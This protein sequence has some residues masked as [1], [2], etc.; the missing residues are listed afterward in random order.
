MISI[1]T[2]TMILFATHS[3]CK[4]SAKLLIQ[5]MKMAMISPMDGMEKMTEYMMKGGDLEDWRAARKPVYFSI[6]YRMKDE[7]NDI[8]A[9]MTSK[10]GILC[11]L[12]SIDEELLKNCKKYN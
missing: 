5:C 12:A 6:Q 8:A 11:K 9:E 3:Y 1:G 10:F 7:F 2:N 4:P